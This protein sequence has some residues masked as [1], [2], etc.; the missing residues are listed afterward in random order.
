MV[1]EELI[2]HLCQRL[3]PQNHLA[4]QFGTFYIENGNRI[5]AALALNTTNE[6]VAFEDGQF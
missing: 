1:A 5:G 3:V 4:F 2:S 6:L